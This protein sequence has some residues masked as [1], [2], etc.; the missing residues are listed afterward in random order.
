[1]ESLESRR[2]LAT[3]G[4]RLFDDVD[5]DRVYRANSPADQPLPNA[6]VYLDL[7]N[8]AGFDAGEPNTRTGPDGRYQFDD[9]AAGN[10]TVR[11]AAA[12][13]QSSP[14]AFFGLDVVGPEQTQLVEIQNDGTT[15]AIAGVTPLSLSGLVQTNDGSF[16]A[17]DA[18]NDQ[19]FEIAAGSGNA[20]LVS[21]LGFDAFAGLAYNPTTETLYGVGTS[22]DDPTTTRLFSVD[23]ASGIAFP[24][25]VGGSG[26]NAASDLSFN[27]DTNRVDGYDPTTQQFFSF[28][29]VGALSIDSQVD[30]GLELEG[31]V[32]QSVTT[33]LS[34]PNHLPGDAL[35]GVAKADGA[36]TPLFG[37][38]ETVALTALDFQPNAN[39]PQRVTV[40]ETDS[41]LDLDFAFALGD[42]RLVIDATDTA[43]DLSRDQ[44]QDQLSV[45]LGRAPTS[46]VVVD[47]VADLPAGIRVTPER[48][49]F[50]S[51]NWMTDQ[52]V[53]FE[54]LDEDLPGAVT[55]FQL[56]VNPQLSDATWRSIPTRAGTITV[57]EI[58]KVV[59]EAYINEFLFDTFFFSEI[60]EAHYLELRGEANAVLPEGTYFLAID[61]DGF[62]PGEVEALIDLSGLQFGSNGLMVFMP[63]GLSHPVDNAANVIRS[64]G[65]GLEGLPGDIFATTRTDGRIPGDYLST[66]TYMIV[67]TDV[68]PQLQDDFDVDDDGTLDP[69]LVGD[70]TTMDSVARVGGVNSTRVERAYSPTVLFEEF[71]PGIPNYTAPAGATELITDTIDY[72]GRIGDSTGGAIGD[73]L[74]GKIEVDET[75]NF[76][77]R[78][79]DDI[80]GY[81][82]PEAFAFRELDHLG[83][84]NFYGAIRGT[85]FEDTD[86][87][88]K[89]D[90]GEVPLA[91]ARVLAD[92]NGNGTRDRITTT[93]EPNN[94]A[95]DSQVSNAD[96]R[97]TIRV[98]DED[99]EPTL[100]RA[101]VDQETNLLGN[102]NVFGRSTNSGITLGLWDDR[103]KFEFFR[104]VNEVSLDFIGNELLESDRTIGH[105]E[106][107]DVDGNLLRSRR[108]FP[109]SA[110]QRTTLTVGSSFF[111]GGEDRIAYAVAYV[112][113]T[114]GG[115]RRGLMDRLVFSQHELVTT[116][117]D[118]GRYTLPFLAPDAYQTVLLD[119]TYD[120]SN[121]PASTPISQ[122]ENVRFDI[123][124]YNNS[125]PQMF[126]SAFAVDEH[127][128]PGTVIGQVFALD[129]DPGQEVTF[130]ILSSSVGDAI[131]LNPLTGRLAVRR[132]QL[133]DFEQ[134]S[135]AVLTVQATDP[136]G[137]TATANV[138][139]S[140]RDVNDRPVI[141]RAELLVAEDALPGSLVGQ[142]LF[143]DVDSGPAGQATIEILSDDPRFEIDPEN[144]RITV[145]PGATFDFETEPRI[146]LLLQATDQAAPPA[147]RLAEVF[148]EVRDVNESPSILTSEI[149]V[150]ETAMLNQPVDQIEIEDPDRRQNHFYQIV[151]GTGQGRFT[152]NRINGTVSLGSEPLDFETTDTFTLDVLVSDSGIPSLSA[153]QMV[154]VSVT[155]VNEPPQLTQVPD[156]EVAENTAA[157]T[158]IATL[159][160]FDPDPGQIVSYALGVGS[161]RFVVD[162]ATGV[163]SIAVGADL[164][165]ENG[166][167][168]PLHVILTDDAVP[169]ASTLYEL[170]VQLIDRPES[171]SIQT[172]GFSLDEN[173]EPG[174]F[175]G[176]VD[177][178]DP[179]AGSTLQYAIT[180]GS[181][182][183]RLE[184]DSETGSLRVAA[185]ATFDFESEPA[186]DLEVTATDNTDL[187]DTRR[188]AITLLDGNETP[189]FTRTVMNQLAE[190][191]QPFSI[192]F[193]S[194]IATDPDVGQVPVLS[195]IGV[196]GPLA[197][198]L[199]FDSETNTLAGFPSP[200]DVGYHAVALRAS[201]PGDPSASAV[202]VF[203]IEVI[204]S[205]IPYQNGRDRFDV[206][207]DNRVDSL[208][209]LAIIN[210]LNRFGVG[211]IVDTGNFPGYI[212]VDGDMR[213]TPRDAL[214]VIR[215]LNQLN[216]PGAVN[217]EAVAFD[218]L[219]WDISNALS[220]RPAQEEDEALVAYL[221]DLATL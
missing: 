159:V 122:Y 145:M 69:D 128:P 3:L 210:Y 139:V 99:L 136:Q 196:D 177:A 169:A 175:V 70:W 106:A 36:V 27:A 12:L 180:G 190:A 213:A 28:S 216:R 18:D 44:L 100:Y 176:I 211:P 209:V 140:L 81:A 51:E 19:L 66:Y 2:L 10:Y 85:V 118:Q 30:P 186:L 171:P 14:S 187:S 89:F 11:H 164:D 74:A 61:G 115:I 200:N 163:L 182:A 130:S 188:L 147:S 41:V 94:Y 112:D 197:G 191:G 64:S 33:V 32:S 207:N 113:D 167:T 82:A 214:E 157:G 26:I 134:S 184:L 168:I 48:L 80:F 15:T 178:F 194:D 7:N 34:V 79:S 45:R 50:T 151:G 104:P 204:A 205:A 55:P 4:G 160:G 84:T 166:S 141:E 38:T 23:L 173:A 59:T 53:T 67:Q 116:S 162:P 221:D 193:E 20:S 71:S 170:D 39:V 181:A 75:L 125:N 24:I 40:A 198:W 121:T 57:T 72:I 131:A 133:L 5:G 179:D 149:V 88:G 108:T 92:T 212:D 42:R 103:L 155:D 154:V 73:W 172:E 156:L 146:A 124:A 150:P 8:N 152:I 143:S 43:I 201:D 110:G 111:G 90:A 77:F 91:G 9:L 215:R 93:V 174:Q 31:F 58:P 158:E 199:Q 218:P 127:A 97:V 60:P 107:Y 16:F 95:V 129:P 87:D 96:P 29:I 192:S 83:S 161:D 49:V 119:A 183:D 86:R 1:M 206:D 47:V 217:G 195:V 37:L 22:D 203:T 76:P 52:T 65:V 54:L 132:P 148:V 185:G 35:R 25:G 165:F 102:E 13:P 6:M 202:Q 219:A 120:L 153:T 63:N 101:S 142:V 126:D 62:F 46:N 78:F 17:L 135:T 220:S 138:T 114:G 109:L 98:V 137:A 123:G 56:Q 68:A 117:D 21:D 189:V 144:G 208:D 105:L